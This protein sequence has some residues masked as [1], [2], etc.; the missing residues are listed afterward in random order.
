[1]TRF[2][3]GA[4]LAGALWVGLSVIAAGA[5]ANPRQYADALQYAIAL[6]LQQPGYTIRSVVVR[7]YHPLKITQGNRVWQFQVWVAYAH[8]GQSHVVYMVIFPDGEI[9]DQA[10]VTSIGDTGGI[11][12]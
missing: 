1:V 3:A 12:G 11:L 4:T 10:M 7:P 5:K 6:D 9:I 2:L 8:R